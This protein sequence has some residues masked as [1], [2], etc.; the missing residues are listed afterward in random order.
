MASAIDFCLP[1]NQA[2]FSFLFLTA[3]GILSPLAGQAVGMPPNAEVG[4]I[5]KVLVSS[6]GYG[7]HDALCGEDKLDCT[8]RF[9]D[10]GVQAGDLLIPAGRFAG[11]TAYDKSQR[12]CNMFG[13]CYRSVFMQESQ[14]FTLSFLDK[15]NKKSKL[16]VSFVNARAALD[17]KQELESFTQL[18][19]AQKGVKLPTFLT[20]EIAAKD[21]LTLTP[22]SQTKAIP[23]RAWEPAP[24]SSTPDGVEVK[25]FYAPTLARQPNPGIFEVPIFIQ[26]GTQSA[27]NII[28]FD[29][30]RSI[31]TSWTIKQTGIDTP[32][33]DAWL[34]ITPLQPDQVA[35]TAAKKLCP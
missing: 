1:M 7:S 24:S 3:F 4:I 31:V 23:F 25:R 22:P 35:F 32:R 12:T 17:F 19:N 29:C 11:W 5:P 34:E 2:S 21:I 18:A 26:T 16:L 14:E 30:T 8:V 6:A 33:R 15:D 20:E 28:R 9:S 27:T 10:S 13:V